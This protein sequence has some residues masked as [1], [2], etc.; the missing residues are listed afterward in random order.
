MI[1]F[2]C[3]GEEFAVKTVVVGQEFRGEQ[4][5]VT[6]PVSVCKSVLAVCR[7]AV[8]LPV[9]CFHASIAPA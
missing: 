7:L 5:D 6:T 4:L 9:A 1:C 8:S 3:S 2:K